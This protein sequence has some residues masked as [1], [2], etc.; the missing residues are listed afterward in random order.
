MA[1]GSLPESTPFQLA[2]SAWTQ[3][4]IADRAT[5]LATGQFN[6]GSWDMIDSN[7]T[8]AE[9]GRYLFMGFETG[10]AG[11]QRYDRLS[12]TMTTHGTRRQRARR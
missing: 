11:I 1:A 8:G 9:A 6:S 3:L 7:R 2:N 4:S 5:Q 10:Q 12:G